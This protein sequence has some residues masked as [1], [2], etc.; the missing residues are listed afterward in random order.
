MA[1]ALLNTSYL[2][3]DFNDPALDTVA[4]LGQVNDCFPS[5]IYERFHEMYQNGMTLATC[6]CDLG[7][8]KAM[9]DVYGF[10]DHTWDLLQHV[11][12]SST[13]YGS[14]WL[15]PDGSCVERKGLLI[16]PVLL[17]DLNEQAQ[18]LTA[19]DPPQSCVADCQEMRVPSLS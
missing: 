15:L 7:L 1:L 6:L 9:F 18:R 5:A 11:Y 13:Q 10:S 12:R 16:R 3:P 4:F 8:D 19:W 17:S 14:L 2:L